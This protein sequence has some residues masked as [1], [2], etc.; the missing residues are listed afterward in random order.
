MRT[1]KVIY[2]VK[3][4]E[5]WCADECNWIEH[6]EIVEAESPRKAQKTF[7]EEVNKL[8]FCIVGRH[9]DTREIKRGRS[10]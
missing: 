7:R 10:P 1:W 4:S 2:N 6:V 5:L 9:V 8:R 3:Y